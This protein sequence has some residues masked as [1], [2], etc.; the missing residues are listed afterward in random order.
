MEDDN[1]LD[2][3]EAKADKDQDNP[4]NDKTNL[5]QKHAAAENN[6]EQSNEKPIDQKKKNT[7]DTDGNERKENT[8]SQIAQ[9]YV[10]AFFS[11]IF[12]VI[13]V[14][15][16]PVAQGHFKDFKD[17]LVTVSG[18]LSGP[19]GFIIGYYFKSGEN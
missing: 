12:I 17:M 14:C 11:V 18:I 19:L 1:N 13:F 2:T 9:I 15:C 10:K 8:R 6:S 4:S 3:T 16:L 5:V 7:I